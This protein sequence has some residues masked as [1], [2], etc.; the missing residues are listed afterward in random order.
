M[1]RLAKMS[2][3]ARVVETGSF[4]AAAQQ[5]RL[6]ATMVSKHVRELEDQLGVKLLNRT[7]R[8]VSL[9]DVGAFFYER[10][11]PL[12]TELDELEHMT[13]HMHTSP[14]GLVRVSAPPTFGAAR[15]APALVDFAALYPDV[16]VE[17][18]LTDRTVDLIEEG[19]DLAVHMGDSPDSSYLTRRLTRFS[20]IICSTPDYL[21]RRGEPTHPK[22]L[23]EHNCILPVVPGLAREWTF[24]GPDQQRIEVKPGGGIRTNSPAAQ[25]AATLRGYGL[26]LQPSYYVSE[27]LRTGK[28]VHVLKAFRAPEIPVRLLYLPGRHM[29]AKLRVFITFLCDRF[30][31]EME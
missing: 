19:F 7:T 25:L 16:T 20:T 12:L 17:L 6:S 28:L 30:T 3:F 26:T 8:R 29:S 31:T 11:A 14:R 5:L 22:E 9:T 18:I 21:A 24:I 1:D 27:E 4:S 2:A 15:I 13:S 23:E 10:C